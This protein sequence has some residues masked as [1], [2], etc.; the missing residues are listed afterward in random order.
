MKAYRLVEWGQ[1]GQYVEDVPKPDPGPSEILVRVKAVGLCHSDLDMMDSQPGQAPYASSLKPGYTLGHEIAGLVESLGSGVSDLRKG[2]TVVVHHMR[3]CGACEFCESGVEQHCEY[4]R[5]GSIGMT[6]GCGFDGGLAEFIV[7]PRTELISVGDADPVL[8]SPLT[9]AGVTAY[10]SCRPFWPLLRPGTTAAVIGIGG[11]G[12]YAIQF[13]KLRTAARIIA[14]DISATRLDLAKDLGADA[15]V[16]SNQ[17]A[18]KTILAI[19]NNKGVDC[20]L[21]LVGSDQSLELAAKT[22]RPQGFISVAGMSGG[23]VR[24]GW[25]LM[26]TGARFAT[27]LGSTRQDLHEV[28]HLALQGRLRIDIDRFTFDQIPQAYELLRAGKLGGRAVIV[29]D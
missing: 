27:S 9:D 25:N 3:H 11:L 18:E 16:L 28:C 17:D 19:T 5:R 22:V 1:P 21:D 20:I 12:S 6:R 26:A 14:V 23:S 4:F 2:E 15:T 8:F 29:M 7:V 13:L 10:A 24:L